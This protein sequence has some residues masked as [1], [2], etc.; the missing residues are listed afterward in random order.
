MIGIYDFGDDD[1]FNNLFSLRTIEQV[2]KD[3]KQN[4][5]C[6]RFPKCGHPK[7]QTFQFLLDQNNF[8]Y[9]KIKTSFLTALDRYVGR[10]IE[11]S[12]FTSWA[13]KTESGK[14]TDTTW[15][16]HNAENVNTSEHISG[17]FYLTDTVIGTEFENDDCKLILKP[18]KFKWYIW[19]SGLPHRPI[20]GVVNQNRY[21]IATSVG[22]K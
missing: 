3:L 13:Y 20:E 8:Y 22:I 14:S 1:V 9:S 10:R 4:P 17:L 21:T 5:C 11:F 2:E 19:N 12:Y 6:D 15:H 16:I 7:T 18:K